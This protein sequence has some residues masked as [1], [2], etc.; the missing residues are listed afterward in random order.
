MLRSHSRIVLIRF[1]RLT[2]R[3]VCSEWSLGNPEA[4]TSLI[5]LGV[6]WV[7]F[8]LWTQVCQELWELLANHDFFSSPHCYLQNLSFF[9]LCFISKIV[10][11]K[12]QC[13]THVPFYF[14]KGLPLCE[15]GAI[16]CNELCTLP[17]AD[18]RSLDTPRGGDFCTP[19][20]GGA[21]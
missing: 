20:Q 14:S 7:V 19:E 12:I 17:G 5:F 16:R 1:V 2:T 21:S 18:P 6:L 4:S 11:S 9:L 13:I 10:H 15:L 3:R 8:S